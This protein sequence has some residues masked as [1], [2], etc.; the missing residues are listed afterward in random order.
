MDASDARHIEQGSPEWLAARCGKI[1][2]SRFKDVLSQPRSKRDKEAG[3]LSGTAKTYMLTLAAETLTGCPEE[4]PTTKAMQHGND[5][6]P[7]ARDLYM[8]ITGAKVKT[9]GF[10]D[11]PTER[12]VG[13]SPDGLVGENGGVEIKCPYT[14]RVHLGYI[15]DGHKAH[16]AQIQGGMWVT[17]REWWDFITY[18]P[19]AN[20][21]ESL[22]LA[23]IRVYRDEAFID[24]LQSAV[25]NFRERLEEAI[26]TLIH[27]TGRIS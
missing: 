19:R 16:D 15:L 25:R 26:E 1:T 4:V 3:V 18:D 2:A 6:E 14:T 5:Y 22:G 23:H 13:C 8:Q 17:E 10:V 21:L 27:R 12:S 11:H 9:V 24:T 20:P 7:V